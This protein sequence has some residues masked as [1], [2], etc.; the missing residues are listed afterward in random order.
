M[1]KRICFLFLFA[2]L[3][4]NFPGHAAEIKMMITG[5]QGDGQILREKKPMAAGMGAECQKADTLKTGENGQMDVTW[6]GRLGCRVLSSTELSLTDT[7]R[8]TMKVDIHQGSVIL[9]V[10]SLPKD[11]TFRVET[12]TAIATVRGTQFWGRVQGADSK[13][14]VV[15]FA[16]RQ[17]KV[18]IL[19]KSSSKTF[20]VESGEAVDIPATGSFTPSVRTLLPAE[21]KVL[22]QADT[23]K[24]DM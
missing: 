12:P 5:M 16:V 20:F 15:L 22:D 13:N 18:E 14:S 4:F 2:L 11:S 24:T 21:V 3:L 23:I 17:G 7:N 8:E 10:K 9:N 19:E 1:K 6:N